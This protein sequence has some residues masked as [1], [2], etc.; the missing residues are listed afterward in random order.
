MNSKIFAW[1]ARLENQ[2]LNRGFT[3]KRVLE[4]RVTVFRVTDFTTKFS[5]A[6]EILYILLAFTDNFDFT[7]RKKHIRIDKT[8]KKRSVKKVSQNL[9]GTKY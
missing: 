3:E 5:I 6:K 7:L 4:G 9:V 8:E 1:V 2:S